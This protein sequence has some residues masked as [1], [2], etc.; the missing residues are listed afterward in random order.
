MTEMSTPVE[1]M[2]HPTEM[3]EIMMTGLAEIRI[4]TTGSRYLWVTIALQFRE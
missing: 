1:G 3:L 2:G 4:L